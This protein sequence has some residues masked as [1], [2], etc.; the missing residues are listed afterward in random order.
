M[1]GPYGKT[2]FGS[3]RWDWN[4]IM[5]SC[6]MK[7]LHQKDVFEMYQN[8]MYLNHLLF[9]IKLFFNFLSNPSNV[10]LGENNKHIRLNYSFETHS[11]NYIGTFLR[12]HLWEKS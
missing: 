10:L 6:E 9:T 2:Y 4:Q 5:F 8:L 11:D 3:L 7:P 12:K 1:S